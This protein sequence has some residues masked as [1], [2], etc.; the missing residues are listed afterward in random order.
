MR[1]ETTRLRN[2]SGCGTKEQRGLIGRI[3]TAGDPFFCERH[4]GEETKMET[5]AMAGNR[6]GRGME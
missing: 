6:M 5:S 2:R 4:R 1:R 3:D